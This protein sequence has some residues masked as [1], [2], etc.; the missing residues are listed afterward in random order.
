MKY[1]LILLSCLALIITACSEDTIQPANEGVNATESNLQSP[2][3]IQPVDIS[4]QTDIRPIIET[5]CVACH[6][7]YDSPCQLNLSSATGLQR[8]ANKTPVYDG[9]RL[10]AVAPTRLYIDA[11]DEQDWRK[12]GFFSVI[13]STGETSSLMLKML[14]LGRENQLADND[15]MASDFDL[16]IARSNQC[17]TND[18]F[19]EFKQTHAYAG[20]PYAVAGLSDAEFGTIASWLKQGGSL[21]PE[22]T[23]LSPPEY[24]NIKQW[25]TWLNGTT[26]KQRIV[27][28]YVYEHLFIAHLHFSDLPS[29]NFFRLVRSTTPPGEA[30]KPVASPR[31][32]HDP[33]GDFW[34]R[35]M[36]LAGAIV[37][38]THITYALNEQKLARYNQLFFDTNW[39]LTKLPGYSVAERSNPFTTFAP[40]PAKSRYQFMLD[41]AAYFVRTFIRGPV[42]HGQI[43]TDVIRDRFWNLFQSPETDLFINN[44]AYRNEVSNLLAVPGVVDDLDDFLPEWVDYRGRNKQYLQKRQAAYQKFQP[45]GPQVSDL[46]DGDASKPDALLTIFRHHNS[47]AVQTG[48]VGDTP[49]TIWVMDYALFERSFYVLVTNF[50]VFGNVAHQTLT[51]LYFDLIRNGAEQN[52]LRFMPATERRDLID[53]WYQG[54]AQL[55]LFITYDEVDLGIPS[56]IT[57]TSNTPKSEL[58]DR[59]KKA[60]PSI[61]LKPRT[62]FS[63]AHKMLMPLTKQDAASL[64]IIKMLPDVSFLRIYDDSGERQ[65]YSILRDRAHSNVAFMLAE[66]LRYQPD[67]DRLTIYPGILGSYPNFIFNVHLDDIEDFSAALRS[68]ETSEHFEDIIENWGIRRSHADFWTILHDFTSFLRETRPTQA[69]I[70]DINRYQNL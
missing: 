68:A 41:N 29:Q 4:Y 6:A 22:K 62:K 37:Y 49:D 67:K 16:N 12:K 61:L 66:E 23:L 55:K 21:E 50:N 15:K 10:Q 2:I 59:V 54:T 42:C 8:G 18:E 28:R 24:R 44:Q 32:N 5:K 39:R 9:T 70:F 45:T 19:A 65:V 56:A 11:T 14:Q 26:D 36:P 63:D 40:I 43:A 51:R 52:F 17:P 20:M 31:P 27:A 7:C 25:E 46:W 30:I 64:P 60:M 38:K 33:Q 13:D 48:L 3:V 57:Y 1:R 47:A 58:F 69:G 34:Y 53:S 35:L